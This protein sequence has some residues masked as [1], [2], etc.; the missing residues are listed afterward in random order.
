MQEE[1]AE[2]KDGSSSERGSRV[3][4]AIA[5]L[6]D[7]AIRI[8]GTERRFGLDVLFG[9]VPGYGDA[10]AT[11]IGSTLVL[12]AAR[13]GVP[14]RIILVM[15][16]NQLVN[17]VIGSIPVVGDLFSA[18]FKSNARNFRLLRQWQGTQDRSWI[19]RALVW[20]MVLSMIVVTTL[21][22]VAV[23]LTIS[24][25]VLPFWEAVKSMRG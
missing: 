13:A 1:L 16:G 18:F 22:V 10:T 21:S 12:Q 17:G 23:W 19:G 11:A 15:A 4:H 24:W 9:L 20:L 7:D 25:V 6:L 5:H 3:S 8:P 2:G 14:L